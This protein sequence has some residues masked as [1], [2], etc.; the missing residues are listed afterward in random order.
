MTC[1]TN[2][3]H[4]CPRCGRHSMPFGSCMMCGYNAGNETFVQKK[5]VAERCVSRSHSS[6]HPQVRCERPSGH[7]GPHVADLGPSSRAIWDDVTFPINFLE[8]E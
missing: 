1:P 7:D 8:D 6:F 2:C 4:V 5:I 3:E